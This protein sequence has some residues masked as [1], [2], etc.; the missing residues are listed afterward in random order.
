MK[1]NILLISILL[2]LNFV[3]AKEKTSYLSK[4]PKSMSKQTATKAAAKTDQ[5]IATTGQPSPKQHSAL[6]TDVRFGDQSVGGKYQLPMEALSVVENEKS[7][8]DLIGVR[9]NFRDRVARTKGMR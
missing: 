1:T 2:G 8:D 6:S 3:S 7:I 4:N 9:K 5:E